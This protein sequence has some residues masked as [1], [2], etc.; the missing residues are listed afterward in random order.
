MKNIFIRF[1]GV[2][3]IALFLYTVP[4]AI[5]A[6]FSFLDSC[7]SVVAYPCI[8]LQNKLTNPIKRYRESCQLR[9]KCNEEYARL[10]QE[11]EELLKENIELTGMREVWQNIQELVDFKKRYATDTCITANVILKNFSP[12]SHFFLID[13]GSRRGITKDMVAVY[14]NC[15]IGRITEIYPFYSRVTLITD[16]ECKVAALCPAS[17]DQGIHQGCGEL[18]KTHLTYVFDPDANAEKRLKKGELVLSSGEG[19]VFPKG[20]GL[21][22]IDRVDREN[23]HCLV[24]LEPLVDLKNITCCSVVSKG[25]EYAHPADKASK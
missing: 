2:I 23:F 15:L 20:F 9:R 3:L 16:P 13:A 24:T 10:Q 6:R 19:L 1:L 7:L 4:R 12:Q 5:K 18:T 25:A 22:R 8:F 11:R 17:Q 21:G 14:K